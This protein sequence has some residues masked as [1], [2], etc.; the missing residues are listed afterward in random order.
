MRIPPRLLAPLCLGVPIAGLSAQTVRMTDPVS[1]GL[2]VQYESWS[3]GDGLPQDAGGAVVR[4]VSQLSVP[5]SVVVPLGERW[6]LDAG[7]ALA[8]GRVRLAAADSLVGGDRYELSGLT[9]VRVRLT[10][11]LVGDRVLL[12]LGGTIPTGRTE[13]DLE[14]L[15]AQ[16]VLAAPVFGLSAPVL[17]TGAAATAGI[18]VTQ[19]AGRWV[20]ALGASYELHGGYS[21]LAVVSDLAVDFR[22]SDAVRVSLGG[23][24]VLGQ[25]AMSLGLAAEFYGDDRLSSPGNDEFEPF[26]E[27]KSLGPIFTADWRLDLGVAGFRELSLH[28][29]DRYRTRFSRGD[30]TVANSAGNYLDAGIRAVPPLGR[31]TALVAALSVRHQTGLD[32]DRSIA[33]AATL[34]G[35]LTLGLLQE[36]G[37]HMLQPFVRAQAARFES[38]D[39]RVTGSSLGAGVALRLVF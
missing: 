8:S 20:W 39:E 34:G 11:H 26:D 28:V 29:V 25:H 9:D 31:R 17:G 37:G 36:I 35:G 24:V 2:A 7:G 13:L 23:D 3:L 19:P 22:P 14:Q 4:R 16:Q 15:R 27:R 21:P 5:W 6:Q 33:T 30:S 1:A 12:T 10:G 32:V 38:G 18:V